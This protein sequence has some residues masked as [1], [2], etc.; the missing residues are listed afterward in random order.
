MKRACLGTILMALAVVC[1]GPAQ[2]QVFDHFLCYYVPN[3][4]VIQLPLQ[5][6]DQFDAP[7]QIFEHTTQI[8]IMRFCNPVT[9]VANGTTFP[10]GNINHHLTMYQLNPQPIIPRQVTFT[11][12][13]GASPQTLYTSDARV[14]AVP[15]GKGIPPSDPPSPSSDLDHYKCYVASG[16]NANLVVLLT[17]QFLSN[18]RFLVV[19]PVLFCNPVVKING[20]VTTQIQFPNNHLT[21]YAITPLGFSK[22][23][24]I[25]NQFIADTHGLNITATNP[26][27]LCA[28]TTKL[29]WHVVTVPPATNSSA[30][31]RSAPTPTANKP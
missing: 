31:T 7:A 27:M 26:D 6:Q 1:S 12:Q 3:Q 29:A 30:A 4:P 16:P 28:P 15:T 5:L 19:Q 9:K 22:S 10:I 23:I 20:S 2:A 17:D 11:N 21:C 24:N 25:A 18:Q 14:L 13:F 8:Q